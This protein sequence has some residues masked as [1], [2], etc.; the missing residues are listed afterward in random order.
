MRLRG[1]RWCRP[2][3]LCW[4][5]TAASPPPVSTAGRAPRGRARRSVGSWLG[6]AGC[7]AGP[8]R[9][10]ARRRLGRTVV[11]IQRSIELV[12]EGG[13]DRRAGHGADG[14]VVDLDAVF[15]R[16]AVGPERLAARAA[17]LARGRL[18]PGAARQALV[19]VLLHVAL[20][21]AAG[22][23]GAMLGDLCFRGVMRSIRRGAKGAGR[24]HQQD[25]E[26]TPDFHVPAMSNPR[27]AR[28]AGVLPGGAGAGVATL[29]RLW[30]GRH[31]WRFTPGCWKCSALGGRTPGER[32]S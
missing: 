27:A 3:P 22:R 14:V 16:D 30:Q 2:P 24:C 31:A 4:Q 11:V 7:R 25:H 10:T 17:A 19:K 28:K 18:E 32:P 12:L 23:T 26:R 5:A 1:A 9:A 8:R 21:L 29:R 13:V 20:L 6:G 15:D